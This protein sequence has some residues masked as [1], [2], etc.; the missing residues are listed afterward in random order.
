[1][2]VAAVVF[3]AF[4]TL[5]EI[6]QPTHP[7]RQLLREGRRQG[8]LPRADDIRTIMTRCL[9]LSEAALA[10][11][12]NISPSKLEALHQRLEEELASIRPYPDAVEAVELLQAAGLRLAVCSNLAMPYGSVVES[13]FPHFGAYGFSYRIGA[14]KPQP[15]IYQHTCDLLNVRPE[16]ELS[17][18]GRI[19]MIGDSER[20]DRDG[21]GQVGIKG[22]LLRRNGDRASN[23]SHFAQ[24]VLSDR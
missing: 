4:G 15:A 23:L 24:S 21:P 9:S 16:K 2:R 18:K 19:V 7:F 13:I 20:C 22:Y 10:L 17:G 14:M 8:R 6:A 11:G 3:D 12:I 5:V 1:M